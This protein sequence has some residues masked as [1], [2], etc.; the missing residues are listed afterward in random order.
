MNEYFAACTLDLVDALSDELVALGATSVEG[1]RVG[2]RFL[3]DYAL[4]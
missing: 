2:W 4:T 1:V 3:R